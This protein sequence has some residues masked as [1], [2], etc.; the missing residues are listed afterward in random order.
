MVVEKVQGKKRVPQVIE[1]AHEKDNVEA[2]PKLCHIVN[3]EVLELYFNV[4][5]FRREAG[6]GQVSFVGIDRDYAFRTPLFHFERIESAVTTY[7]EHGF[8]AQ[9]RRNGVSESFPL[10]E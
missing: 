10:D 5:H 1:H 9:V 6:L 8:S 3:R 7:V 4:I 2:L